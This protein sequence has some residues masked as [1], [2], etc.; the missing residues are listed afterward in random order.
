MESESAGYEVVR[1]A[2]LVPGGPA[3]LILSAFP[4]PARHWREAGADALLP[5]PMSL[6]RLLE[7]IESLGRAANKPR[8]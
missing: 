7:T 5:K 1:A 4:M 3:V 6:E 2:K 8:P